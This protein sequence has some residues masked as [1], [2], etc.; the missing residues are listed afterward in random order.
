MIVTARRAFLPP[1]AGPGHQRHLA[2]GRP[3]PDETRAYVAALAPMINRVPTKVQLGTF[4]R[5]FAWANS[6]LFATRHAGIPHNSRSAVNK[7]ERRYLRTHAIVDLSALVR[8]RE[9]VRTF[10]REIRSP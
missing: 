3:L 4:A 9:P 2:T 10:T 5:S 8:A 7:V 1:D 6:S